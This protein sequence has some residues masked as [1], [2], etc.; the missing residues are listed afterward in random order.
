MTAESHEHGPHSSGGPAVRE[1]AAGLDTY[2]GD[3][4]GPERIRMSLRVVRED[5]GGPAVLFDAYARDLEDPS[6][7]AIRYLVPALH[8]LR[9]RV[10]AERQDAGT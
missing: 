4:Y 9:N 1:D 2:G 6:L 10:E 3:T 7:F 8:A 5:D